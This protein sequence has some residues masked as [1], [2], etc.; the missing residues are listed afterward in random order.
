MCFD[1]T[2]ADQSFVV[3]GMTFVNVV[4]VVPQV[5]LLL[6]SFLLMKLIQLGRRICELIY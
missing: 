4:D 1:V 6:F 2:D 3:C 5:L